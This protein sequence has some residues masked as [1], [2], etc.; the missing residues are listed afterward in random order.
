MVKILMKFK[1]S[2]RQIGAFWF[3]VVLC[4]FNCFAYAGDRAGLRDVRLSL[5]EIDPKEVGSK[6]R[7][8]RRRVI[9]AAMQLVV[10]DRSK[11]LTSN[12]LRLTIDHKD[13]YQSHESAA[14]AVKSALTGDSL[15]GVGLP[16]SYYAEHGAR[17]AEGSDFTIVSPYATAT[18]LEKYFPNIVLL[19][20]SNRYSAL[21]LS[22]FVTND[23]K[24]GSIAAIVPWDNAFSRNLYEEL[25]DNFKERVELIKI[26]DDQQNLDKVADQIMRSKPQVVLLPTFPAFTGKIIRT[27]HDRGYRGEFVGPSSWG[28][29][30]GKP[31][32]ALTKDLPIKA[33]T[34]RE[35]SEYYVTEQQQQFIERFNRVS[36]MT[37]AAEAGLYYDATNLLIDRIV[38]AGSRVSRS[39]LMAQLKKSRTRCGIFSNV[40]D[41]KVASSASIPFYVVSL[42]AGTFS[43]FKV[44]HI[45][46]K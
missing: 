34:V 15:A 38:E 14:I 17:V 42:R 11:D 28:E 26:I 19:T 43:K 8:E 21:A 9:E 2:S 23:L 40:C 16:T 39:S 32:H 22:E 33:Y 31:L 7:P 24:R 20:P 27:L 45:E 3:S 18:S 12:G 10:S 37:Y 36:G 6:A 1:K 4:T 25:P 46:N 35:T 5:F 29:G 30:T 13:L 44:M 41:S